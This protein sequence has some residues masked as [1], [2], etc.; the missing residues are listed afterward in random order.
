MQ[1]LKEYKFPAILA[2]IFVIIGTI[3]YCYGYLTAR[4]GVKF[5][6]F[7]GRDVTGMNA[8]LM[9]A[10]QAEEGYYVFEDRLTP[11]DLPR[12]VI[13]A[14]WWLFGRVARWTGLSLIA[15]FHIGRVVTITLLMFSAYFL[16]SQCL[17]TVFQRRFALTLMVFGSGLGWIFWVVSKL[18]DVAPPELFD[19][20]G[21]SIFGYLI[22]R[23]HFIR[24]YVFGMLMA[25]FLLAGERSGKRVLFVLAGLCALARASI[26]PYGIPEMYLI[27]L[28]FPTLL[29]LKERRFSLARYENYALAALFPIPAVLS[30][31]WLVYTG[32]LGEVPFTVELKPPYFIDLM[33]WFG[34][35]FILLFFSFEGFRHLRYMRSS[36]LLLVLW[37]VLAF[38]IAQ[39]YPY[40]RSGLE[41]GIALLLVP[42][43]LATAGPLKR[44]YRWAGRSHM[45]ENLV[46]RGVSS[47]VIKRTM[48]CAFVI[49]CSLS[50]VIVY[51]R[52]FT[53]LRDCPPPYYISDD[54]YDALVWLG[55]NTNSEDTVL[56]CPDTG[57]HIPRVAGNKT[58]TGQ[59]CFT[60]D[61]DEKNRRAERF[62]ALRGDNEFKVRL[63]TEYEIRYVLLGPHERRPGGILPS[64]HGWLKQVYSRGAVAVYEVVPYSKIHIRMR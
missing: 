47:D 53:R 54:L 63:I 26:R 52:M 11:E 62:F 14:E 34:V 64:D 56:A 2:L 31:V 19:I 17:D 41:A 35:P 36:S 57:T 40:L 33:I 4:P 46:R 15:V 5:M 9:L 50:S 23:P 7:I 32:G 6:G 38:L 13:N 48:A 25:A 10:K 45:W 3:P 16:I 55:E 58:F 44:M 27:F 28:L 21:I 20:E 8:Y 24:V 51:G 22:N 43:I 12:T 60:L 42:S 18:R 30:S 61:F 37:I 49:F 29:C 59:W 39:S 1:R